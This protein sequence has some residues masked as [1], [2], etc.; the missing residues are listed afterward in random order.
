MKKI[1]TALLTIAMMM[2]TSIVFADDDKVEYVQI[3]GYKI[4]ALACQHV[5]DIASYMMEIGEFKGPSMKYV[6]AKEFVKKTETYK[7]ACKII[8]IDHNQVIVEAEGILLKLYAQQDAIS[9]REGRGPLVFFSPANAKER[10]A[11][12]KELEKQ[13]AQTIQ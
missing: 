2:T 7:S 13:A 10:M 9:I 11:L 8:D 1:L 5:L 4:A 12:E 3:G 6:G